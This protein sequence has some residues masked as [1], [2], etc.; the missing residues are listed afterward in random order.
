MYENGNL[1]NVLRLSSNCTFEA[2]PG[3]RKYIFM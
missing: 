3:S 1:W 2:S